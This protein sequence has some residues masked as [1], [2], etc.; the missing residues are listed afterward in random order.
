MVR[1]FKFVLTLIIIFIY[2]VFF[3]YWN[4]KQFIYKP[5]LDINTWTKKFIAQY[6]TQ[7]AH[8]QRLHTQHAKYHGCQDKKALGPRLA[9]F[10]PRVFLDALS[11]TFSVLRLKKLQ[12]KNALKLDFL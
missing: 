1:Y 11:I 2:V 3:F 12:L 8:I 6:T 4:L 9:F 5:H 7:Q 10:A